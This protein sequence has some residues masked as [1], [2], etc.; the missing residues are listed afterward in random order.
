MA[1]LIKVPIGR[2]IIPY[3]LDAE[4]DE[5]S[6]VIVEG[7]I[8]LATVLGLFRMAEDS[9]LHGPEDEDG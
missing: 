1:E 9:L 2:I 7:E 3:G 4:G 5:I 6:T 8:G